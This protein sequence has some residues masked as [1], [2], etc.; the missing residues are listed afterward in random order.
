MAEKAYTTFQI[1]KICHVTHRTVLSWINQGKI[2]AFRT[3]GGHSRV[4]EKDLKKFLDEFNIPFPD[5]LKTTKVEILVVDDEEDILVLIEKYLISDQ[6]LKEKITV[7]TCR[8]GVD[9]LMKIG[10][11]PPDI[12]VLDICLP[13]IDG[14]EVC[15][16][17]RSN[18]DTKGV[19]I[20]AISGHN[21]DVTQDKILEAGANEFLP[22]PFEMATLKDSIVKL[23]ENILD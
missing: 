23:M 21:I 15:E 8:N 12:M 9:A 17:I 6:D 20:L 2:N 10:K 14:Y 18:P 4:C 22:K 1:S 19:C 7:S 13:N 5:D 16:R 3:P 11:T